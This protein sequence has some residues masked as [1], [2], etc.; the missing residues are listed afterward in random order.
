MYGDPMGTVAKMM[1]DVKERLAKIDS[2]K[3]TQATEKNIVAM[4]DDLIKTEEDKAN[5]QSQSPQNNQ[6]KQGEK[7]PGEGEPKEGDQQG[8]LPNSKPIKKPGKKGAPKSL[9]RN[10]SDPAHGE[11]VAAGTNPKEKGDWVGLPPERIEKLKEMYRLRVN[12][13]YRDLI[14]DYNRSISTGENPK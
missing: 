5:S 14:V 10:G 9:L 13:R 8:K 6:K 2:G 4:L 3:D 11:N 1:A 12:E 7:K